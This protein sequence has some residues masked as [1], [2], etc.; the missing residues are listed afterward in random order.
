MNR[1]WPLLIIIA[2]AIIGWI[3][4]I[5]YL[6]KIKQRID[7][8]INYYN[9]FFDLIDCL[10]STKQVNQQLYVKLTQGVNKMQR[11]LGSDGIIDMQ[12]PLRGIR[13]P[14]YQLLINFLPEVNQCSNLW[15]SLGYPN[16]IMMERFLSSANACRD[17]FLRHIGTL[18]EFEQ[19]ERANLL[20]PFSCL[21]DGIS[22]ILWIPKYILASL[23]LF[24]ARSFYSWKTKKVAK[25]LS[26]MVAI[27]GLISS[28]ITIVIGWNDFQGFLIRLFSR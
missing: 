27:L 15:D 14:N 4:K 25:S 3:S 8:T 1:F 13:S 24:S 20:N 16:S 26:G 7:A 5:L 9:D 28:I 21:A 10:L 23:G 11:E 17:M 18:E 12:D 2:I 6:W 22:L 19:E